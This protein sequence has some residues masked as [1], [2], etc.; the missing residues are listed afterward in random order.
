MALDLVTLFTTGNEDPTRGIPKGFQMVTKRDSP[1][2]I[3][4]PENCGNSKWAAT[5]TW[6]L[7]N[8]IAQLL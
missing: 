5:M 8:P 3:R 1:S 7:H 2:I 6:V 4:Q